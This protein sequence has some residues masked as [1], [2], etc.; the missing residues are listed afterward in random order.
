MPVSGG[1]VVASGDVLQAQL[2]KVRNKLQDLF[3]AT[4]E[5]A[6]LIDKQGEV[7]VISQKL[8]R[9]PVRKF[10]GGTYQAFN[11]DAGDMGSGSGMSVDKVTAGFIYSNLSFELSQQSVDTTNT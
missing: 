2:E 5:I 1:N 4:S 9:I 7:E 6:G 10:R 8:Y 3:E 11:A